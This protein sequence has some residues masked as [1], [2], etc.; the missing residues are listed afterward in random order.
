VAHRRHWGVPTEYGRALWARWKAGESLADIARA[1]GRT[2]PAISQL[3]AR[4]GGIARPPRQRPRG[5]LTSGDREEI[6]RGLAAGW[7]VRQLARVTHR[8]PSTISREIRRNGGRTFYRAAR[9]DA[10]AWRRARRPKPCRLAQHDRLRR[11]VAAQLH[12]RWAPQQIAGWLVTE[13]P[14]DPTMRVSHETIY[15]SL[16]LQARGVLKKELLAH[17][18]RRRP[19]RRP[20]R[21]PLAPPR[22]SRIPDLVSI[23]ARP[24]AIADRAIPGH[25]EGDL[26]SGAKNTHIITLVERATRYVQLIRVTGKDTTTVINAL[27]RTV[28]RLPQGLMRSLTWDRGQ[29]MTQHG[30]F[31]I[32]T[33]VAVYFCD[34]QSPWQRGSN[35]NTNGLLR[36]YF[37]KGTSLGHFTQRQL[38]AVARQLNMRPRK[39]LGY[40]SPAEHLARAVA[41]TD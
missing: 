13:Y 30:R 2:Q 39:T 34:P 14:D 7:S 21:D 29:E 20:R 5:A 10:H 26:L 31:T 3:V 8:A 40:R 17:L 19:M 9:A 15:R 11:V 33:D 4:E 16:Y 36:Q 37:P 28:P 23:A 35:E 1:L 24:A 22:A 27:I 6:T 25:W 38:D 12:A 18:R 41:A 32:A